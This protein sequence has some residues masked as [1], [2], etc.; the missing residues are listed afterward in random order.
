MNTS[1]LHC[2]I[3]MQACSMPMERTACHRFADPVTRLCIPLTVKKRRECTSSTSSCW[4]ARFR[5]PNRASVLV[6]LCARAN[7]SR[8]C[9]GGQTDRAKSVSTHLDLASFRY[10]NRPSFRLVSHPQMSCPVPACPALLLPCP[11]RKRPS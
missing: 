4:S 1:H 8:C 5:G 11:S 7:S 9:H 10:S 2:T 3:H 6:L